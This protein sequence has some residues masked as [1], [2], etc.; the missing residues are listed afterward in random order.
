MNQLKTIAIGLAL[1][2]SAALI[3]GVGLGES[4]KIVVNPDN[5]EAATNATFAG[6]IDIIDR[7]SV[8]GAFI[9][10]LVGLG[11]VSVPKRR[12]GDDMIGTVI[13][14]TPVWLAAL[15]VLNFSTDIV[16]VLDGSID[17]AA[18]D[19]NYAVFIFF[20]AMST[21]AGVLTLLGNAQKNN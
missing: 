20:M 14:T 9:T 3:L 21:V 4:A 1:V 5:V 16:S 17:Y 15:G 12:N 7:A 2:A 19:D 8:A 6:S 13:R 10:A 18:L 11:F